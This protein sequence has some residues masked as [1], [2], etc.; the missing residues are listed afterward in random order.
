MDFGAL[1]GLNLRV[2]LSSGI[3]ILRILRKDGINGTLNREKNYN[4]LQ[5]VVLQD[6]SI[7]SIALGA[8]NNFQIRAGEVQR[9]RNFAIAL[10]F[11]NQSS[12][13]RH[14]LLDP[15][16]T[17]VTFQV[18]DKLVTKA[19]HKMLSIF[20]LMCFSLFVLSFR[21]FR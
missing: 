15:T 2:L 16:T 13:Q 18:K 9:N 4:Q 7:S 12:C 3:A 17:L 21:S 11:S 14:L 19:I 10:G 20:I 8:G 1:S 6:S 5:L